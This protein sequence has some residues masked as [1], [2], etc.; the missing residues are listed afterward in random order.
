MKYLI[1]YKLKN[2]K[3][4]PYIKDG[5]YFSNKNYLIGI[6][7]DD[8]RNELPQDINIMNKLEFKKYISDLDIFDNND[9]NGIEKSNKMTKIQKN[10]YADDWIII[11]NIYQ[12]VNNKI[13]NKNKLNY[14]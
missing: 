5:G 13:I 2:G 4:P 8:D 12:N 14:K 6:S 9:I 1:K 7:L 11:K 10:K 3:V